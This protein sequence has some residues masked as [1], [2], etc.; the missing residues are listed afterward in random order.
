MGKEIGQGSAIGGAFIALVLEIA[1][2]L[3]VLT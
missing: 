3:V 1:A 2:T